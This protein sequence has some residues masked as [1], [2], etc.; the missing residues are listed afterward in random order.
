[1]I[2]LIKLLPLLFILTSAIGQEISSRVVE[3]NEYF[4]TDEYRSFINVGNHSFVLTEDVTTQRQPPF[5]F[6]L[7]KHDKRMRNIHQ[8]SLDIRYSDSVAIQKLGSKLAVILYVRNVGRSESYVLIKTLNTDNLKFDKKTTTIPLQY[9]NEIRSQFE[10]YE[11]NNSNLLIKY[12][13]KNEETNQ[14]TESG[15]YFYD[16]DLDLLNNSKQLEISK[17]LIENSYGFQSDTNNSLF[18]LTHRT[19]ST[20]SK[21][22]HYLFALNNL[23]NNM[24]KKEIKIESNK[25]NSIKLQFN[26]NNKLIV[27]GFYEEQIDE[28]RDAT[29]SFLF[30]IDPVEFTTERSFNKIFANSLFLYGESNFI[31]NSIKQK[32]KNKED[33]GVDENFKVFDISIK[34]NGDIILIGQQFTFN[35]HTK[36][37][38]KGIERKKYIIENGN[39]LIVTF[40]PN[41]KYKTSYKIRKNQ[42]LI[43]TLPR[44]ASMFPYF[45]YKEVNNDLYFIYSD[46]KNNHIPKSDSLYNYSVGKSEGVIAVYKLSN[47]G[48]FTKSII[49]P[50]KKFN[51]IPA[52]GYSTNLSYYKM[53]F[54]TR[55]SGGIHEAIILD[56]EEKDKR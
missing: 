21:K 32:V 33:I 30:I 40:K 15:F 22:S 25:I 23:L 5:R 55:V 35:Q 31:K 46:N 52:L 53:S 11:L 41:G 8:K 36:K 47:E 24:L 1:M 48:V 44:N 14:I 7:R 20:I 3:I 42:K 4:A 49:L 17:I 28:S 16:K 54:L 51:G 26:Q 12:K 10:A 13:T 37:N 45:A 34:T 19:D 29:G 39:L 18:F 27:G 6:L 38:K 2:K 43:T 50:N 56:F 9:G